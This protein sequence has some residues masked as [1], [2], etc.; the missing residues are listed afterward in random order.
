MQKATV[1]TQDEAGQWVE[2]DAFVPDNSMPGDA[3][4]ETL[5]KGIYVRAKPWHSKIAIVVKL[6]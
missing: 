4:A 3:V 5:V 1:K 6:N 2:I